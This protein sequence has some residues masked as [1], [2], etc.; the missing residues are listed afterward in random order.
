MADCGLKIQHLKT[1]NDLNLPVKC[2]W[3]KS[4][5]RHVKNILRNNQS[6]MDDADSEIRKD[7]TSLKTYAVDGKKKVLI[8][9]QKKRLI[10]DAFSYD[11][12]S[13]RIYVHIADPT[14]FFHEKQKD[15]IIIEALK[16]Y[17]KF[18]F[19]GEKPIPM[20][21][22]ELTEKLLSLDATCF[23]ERVPALTITFRVRKNGSIQ[24]RSIKIFASWISK[25]KML[26]IPEANEH[27]TKRAF[28]EWSGI[29]RRVKIMRKHR[30]AVC[31][32]KHTSAKNNNICEKYMSMKDV[33]IAELM[34]EEL[35]VA[36]NVAAGKYG[37][38]KGIKLVCSKSKPGGE[39]RQS[40]HC[41]AHAM[42]GVDLYAKVT[43]PLRNSEC[44]VNH[45]Q[46]KAALR[47]EEA[48]FKG[49]ELRKEVQYLRSNFA[50]YRK[51]KNLS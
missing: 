8:A 13:K 48:P 30:K 18:Y 35:M 25:P 23:N 20:L 45:F 37:K 12:N 27:I 39:I 9:K 11:R 44:L 40:Y 2:T 1:I 42:N 26:T 47:K 43:S 7:I 49:N 41:G 38:Q 17:Q 21:P 5:T 3:T 6:G 32:D 10:D 51:Y 33:N 36:T 19:E 16:R 14:A 4:Q 24:S 15:P 34:I 22:E 29:L 50:K 46:L 28:V 31:N